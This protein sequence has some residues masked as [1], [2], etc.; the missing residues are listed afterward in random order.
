[1]PEI[2]VP[3]RQPKIID[4]EVCFMFSIEEVER[5]AEPFRFSMVL[6]FSRQRP[7]LDAVRAFI[8]S[9]WG[10]PVV[11]AMK[12]P[13]HVF[14]RMSSEGD[15]NKALSR[16]SCDVNGIPYRPFAWTLEFDEALE[17]S[18]VPIWIFLPRLPPNF[19]HASMLKKLT[20]PIGKFIRRDNATA[21]ATRTDGARVCLEIDS[22]KD[23][24][25][26]F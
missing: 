19:F 2:A 15:F 18:C 10:L 1:M 7:S 4:G 3:F 23:P 13:R 8:C 5:T 14:V 21:C 9:R 25:S 22:L 26:C 11:S 24:L 12:R 17:P 20:A 16:E 6:K